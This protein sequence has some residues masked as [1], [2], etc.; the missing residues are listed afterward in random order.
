MD[1]RIEGNTTESKAQSLQPQPPCA[2]HDKSER[3][4]DCFDDKRRL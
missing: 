3:N 4:D 1:K 2:T